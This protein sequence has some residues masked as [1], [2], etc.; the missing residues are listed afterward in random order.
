[1]SDH[2]SIE[3]F[4]LPLSSPLGTS[5]GEIREREGF[6]V[7]VEADVD[8][9]AVRGVGESTP[10]SGWTES[11]DECESGLRSVPDD[12][13]DAHL[14]GLAAASHGYQM[15]LADAEARLAGVPLA[16]VLAEGALVDRPA[17]TVPVNATIGDGTVEGAVAAA[18]DAVDA[19]YDCLKLKVGAQSTSVDL[20]RVEAVADAVDASLR[21]DANGAWDRETADAVVKLLARVETLE[22][23]E[24]PLPADDV[25]G[26]AELRGQ[27]VDIAV[28]ESVRAVGVEAVLDADAADVVVLKPMALGGPR[29]ATSIARHLTNRGVDPVVTTTIDGAVARA[30]AVHVAATIPD[31][32]PCGLATGSF[33]AEDFGPDPV[34]VASG[35]ISVPDG[36]GNVG[37]RFDHLLWDD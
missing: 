22:Y 14:S 37:D 19:G 15:A 11:L 20:L 4:S 7:G 10:L 30:A 34:P 29:A 12:G 32:R 35:Q 23:V 6:L 3:P 36:P 25:E 21:L 16:T 31:V 18:E 2:V 26:L 9:T 1:M 28:D 33:L 13:W 24:Q 17:T 8:G 27:G 5:A